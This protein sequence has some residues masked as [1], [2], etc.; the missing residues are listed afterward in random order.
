MKKDYILEKSSIYSNITVVK[1]M[2]AA[3]IDLGWWI[4]VNNYLNK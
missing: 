1:S 2:K 3:I 4:Y